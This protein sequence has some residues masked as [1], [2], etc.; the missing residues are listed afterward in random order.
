MKFSLRLICLAA[1]AMICFPS[2]TG[3]EVRISPEAVKKYGLKLLQEKIAVKGLK[4]SY[5][6]IWISDLHV[7][8]NDVS[9]V[10]EGRS[11]QAMIYRRDI[12]FNNPVTKKNPAFLWK[13]LPELL[14]NSG[15]DMVF[16]G[17]DICDM[18]SKANLKLLQQGFKELKVPFIFLREDHD[19]TPWHL[20][21]KDMK[22]QYAISKAIDG[23]PGFPEKEFDDL[24]IAGLD[25]SVRRIQKKYLEQFK[26][27][28]AKGKPVIL[29]MHVPIYPGPQG[30]ALL[31][32]NKKRH[33]WDGAMKLYKPMDEYVN[34]IRTPNGPVK[35]VFS[36]H[37]HKDWAGFLAPGVRQRVFPAAF[38]GFIGIIT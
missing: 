10:A 21:S 26:K 33:V 12:R 4:R 28:C 13:A 3:G 11:R 22:E 15:A 31:W 27:I 23:H 20:A 38:E 9:E 6:F 19:I 35:A 8:D 17:G 29:L 30:S 2:L 14:N 16:F 18:G 36:G 25:Y 32:M 7:I 1:A 24:I 5:S 34:I 37:C